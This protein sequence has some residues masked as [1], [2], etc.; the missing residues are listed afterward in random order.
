L[1]VAYVEQ[2][3]MELATFDSDFDSLPNIV[4]YRP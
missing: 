3:A 2:P 4:R 1:A